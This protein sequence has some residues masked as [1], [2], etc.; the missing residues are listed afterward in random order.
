MPTVKLGVTEMPY[1]FSENVGKVKKGKNKGKAYASTTGDVA[2]ILEDKYHIMEVFWNLHEEEI[3]S[4]LSTSLSDEFES[5]L[6]GKPV[7]VGAFAAGASEVEAMFQKFLDLKEMDALGIPGVPTAASLAG[8]SHRFK[9]P[10][11]KRAPRPSFVDTGLYESSFRCWA[12][13]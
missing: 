7:S 4:A 3:V 5:M 12:D 13:E 10:Y 1:S 6:Q 11:A 8:V 2:E 9:K